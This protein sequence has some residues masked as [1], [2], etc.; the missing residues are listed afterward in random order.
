MNLILCWIDC[1]LSIYRVIQLHTDN[2]NVFCLTGRSYMASNWHKVQTRS[3]ILQV[4]TSRYPTIHL[5]E[6]VSMGCTY[7]RGVHVERYCVTT[8]RL[9]ET[10][11]TMRFSAQT[12]RSV[13]IRKLHALEKPSIKPMK[14][15]NNQSQI[16]NKIT[17]KEQ[18]HE[19]KGRSFFST[20]KVLIVVLLCIFYCFFFNP[21]TA[22]FTIHETS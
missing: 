2:G 4:L 12:Q 5:W 11:T 16:V 18:E 19:K 6:M 20:N 14:T 10:R 22:T 7:T 8:C 15:T 17:E 9:H 3:T 1:F 21:F 13:C